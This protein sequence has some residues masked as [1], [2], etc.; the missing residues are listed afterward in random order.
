MS[1][2]TSLPSNPWVLRT[3]RPNA[4]LRL[5]CFCYAGG[6]AAVFR[7]WQAELG[8]DIEVCAIQL[9][10]RGA[11]FH[12]APLSDLQQVVAQVAAAIAPLCDRPF[13]FFGHSLGALIAYEVA[14]YLH[15][16]RAALPRHLVVSGAQGPRLRSPRTQW[17]KLD[18]DALAKELKELAGTPEEVLDNRELLALVLPA[19]RA[20]FQIAAEYAWRPGMALPLPI[21]VFAGRADSH[22]S[23]SQYEDWFRDSSAGATLHWFDGGHFFINTATADVLAQLARTLAE[24]DAPAVRTGT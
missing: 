12:E 11:R 24:P 16:R 7:P 1:A 10:G 18:D 22:D 5:F 17:H 15:I 19:I 14:R 6:N 2:L 9:P 23:E 4:R 3:A 8:P 13:A 20:D 21:T